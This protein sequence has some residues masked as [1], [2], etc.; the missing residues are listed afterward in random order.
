VEDVVF[1]GVVVG[2][3]GLMVVVIVD[4]GWFTDVAAERRESAGGGGG[5]SRL[6][7]FRLRR[8]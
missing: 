7:G 4:L 3:V 6:G 2:V 1:V 8:F 5:L